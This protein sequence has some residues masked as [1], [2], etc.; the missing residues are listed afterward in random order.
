MVVALL[1]MF[2]A[3]LN[4]QICLC[5][6]MHTVKTNLDRMN[7]TISVFIQRAGNRKIRCMQNLECSVGLC[8][9]F[10]SSQKEEFY[11]ML[12]FKTNSK[13]LIKRP[14]RKCHK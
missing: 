13:P 6:I 14:R 11:I 5:R 4:F 3:A 1:S 9:T 12:Y 7:F 2:P 8:S 10:S